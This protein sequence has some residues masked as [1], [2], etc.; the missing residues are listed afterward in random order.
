MIDLASSPPQL[1]PTESRPRTPQATPLRNRS[2]RSPTKDKAR[3]PPTPHRESTD[4]FW[5]QELTNDWI[6][7]HSPRKEKSS[8]RNLIDQL[9]DFDLSD[10]EDSSPTSTTTT[11]TSPQSRSKS[12]SP[13]KIPSKTAL[14]KAEAEERRI[15][16]ARRLSFDNRKHD[17]ARAFFE[18]LDNA[19]SGGE[20]QRLA[21]SSGGVA[22]VWSKTL[23]KTAGRAL[24]SRDRYLVAE[25]G[26]L[27]SVETKHAAKIELAERIIDDDYRLIN[28]LAH[29]YC[30]L[31]AY[32]I[33]KV[34][35]NPHGPTFKAWARKC[36]EAMKDHP[37]YGGKINITT[38]HSY[39]I[40]YKYVWMCGGCKV[41]YGR[42]SKS[43]DPSRV[44]CGACR[45]RLEQIKPKPRN[46]SPK[47]TTFMPT[48]QNSQPSQDAPSPQSSQSSH[49]DC[50]F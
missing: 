7:H 49:D 6:D 31:T 16:K 24:W 43:I 50:G 39:K 30:H 19:V 37:R 11:P 12:M 41:T 20:I 22:I 10:N 46:V 5:S 48:F 38:R 26:A 8:G 47:K 44:S 21:R 15:A 28:T 36:A 13:V 23:Q 17:S 32:M 1:T 40:D 14:K 25:S 29:E 3:I 35:N 2:S 45:G 27:P 33:S 9:R 4:A 42:H 34:T 18:E